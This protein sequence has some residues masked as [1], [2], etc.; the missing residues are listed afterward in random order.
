MKRRS[1][2]KRGDS[3][4]QEEEEGGDK[5]NPIF[6]ERDKKRSSI[7]EI[8]DQ[9]PVF[10]R[11]LYITVYSYLYYCRVLKRFCQE[12]FLKNAFNFFR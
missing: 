12:I 3:D 1:D 4:T 10:I 7:G 8:E 2:G 9:G 11:H 5:E 6:R